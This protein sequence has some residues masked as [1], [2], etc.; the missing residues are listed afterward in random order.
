M[1]VDLNDGSKAAIALAITISGNDVYVAGF[2]DAGGA[3]FVAKYWKN[4]APVNLTDAYAVS[5]QASSIF[6]SNP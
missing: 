2:E 1:P 6:I 4:G 3:N 5:A